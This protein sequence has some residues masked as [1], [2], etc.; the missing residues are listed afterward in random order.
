MSLISCFVSI[1]ALF[2]AILA[3]ALSFYEFR[4]K[5]TREYNEMLS[6]LNE[7]YLTDENI[8]TVVK[9]LRD[10][11]ASDTKP[12]PYQTE[13]FLRFFEELGI[14][15]S[16]KSIQVEHVHKFFDYYLMKFDLLQ[17]D[18]SMIL[19]EDLTTGDYNTEYLDRYR[20]LLSSKRSTL[21][22]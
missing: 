17:D 10:N 14:Y 11:E 7:R 5:Q 2:V 12:T 22:K 9:Y 21:N 1:L 13:M 18:R 20:K 6:R 3:F 16:N 15:L 19:H 8:Q 4:K